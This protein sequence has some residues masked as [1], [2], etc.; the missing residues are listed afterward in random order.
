M[1]VTQIDYNIYIY[2]N[3][4]LLIFSIIGRFCVVSDQTRF[5]LDLTSVKSRHM[6]KQIILLIQTYALVIIICNPKCN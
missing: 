6:D 3:N 2:G 5:C 4:T 1:L